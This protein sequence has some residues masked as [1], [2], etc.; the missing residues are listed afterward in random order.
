[1]VGITY[2]GRSG[3]QIFSYVFARLLAIHNNLKLITMFPYHKL[4]NTTPHEEG[5]ILNE[6]DIFVN[7]LYH[8]QHEKLWFKNKMNGKVHV[9]GFFQWPNY[10]EGKEKLIKSFFNLPPVKK[11]PK[12]EIVLHYRLTDY[13]SPGLKSVIH[14][15]WYQN[16]LGSKIRF[17][18][19]C[20]LYI[21]TDDPADKLIKNLLVFKHN[22]MLPEIISVSPEHDFH[23]IREFDTIICGN[24]SFSWWAAFLS[25][26]TNIYTFADWMREPHGH[27]IK[28]AYYS[29]FTPIKGNWNKV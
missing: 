13:H 28:N 16:I 25:E 27:K 23:F 14:P 11:R 7:D 19:K 18:N 17:N 5:R 10:Y 8:D 6:P 9:S 12:E 1:M 21:V 15:G 24:S 3:N 29:R 2:H 4:L 26:A 22:G 20:K